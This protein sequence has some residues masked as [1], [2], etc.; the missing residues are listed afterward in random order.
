FF[1]MLLGFL[2]A[3]ALNSAS[4]W[5]TRFFRGMIYLPYVT[6]MVSMAMV[7]LW[8]Y[9][10]TY[11]VFNV[12][13]EALGLE[14]QQWLYDEKLALGAMIVLGIWK[15]VG[16]YMTLYLA[17]LYNIPA[18]LYEAAAIDGARYWQKV[19]R[20]TLPMLRPVTFFILITGTINA[21]NV[22]EQVNV[23]TGGGPMNATTTIVH[24]I[25]IRAFTEYRMGYGAAE[26]VFLLVI[27]LIFTL[28][29]FRYGNQGQDL[30][31]G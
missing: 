5:G 3:L 8:L 14:A 28:L 24:Q 25:Y 6:S 21:F 7:W 18:Y 30:D 15:G 16:Y 19:F 2:L 1:T 20:I 27:I 11:G 31:M 26:A 23:M 13:M 12:I 4:L 9:D 29:N 22:F 17:G 10:P